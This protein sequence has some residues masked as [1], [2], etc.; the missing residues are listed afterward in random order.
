MW[1]CDTESMSIVS[2]SAGV[3]ESCFGNISEVISRD[4]SS[5]AVQKP[6]SLTPDSNLL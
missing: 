6:Y 4:S 5:R 1:V 3:T 2:S